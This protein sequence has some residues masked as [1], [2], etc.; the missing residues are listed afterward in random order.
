[1]KYGESAFDILYLVFA[2]FTGIVILLRHR[3]KADVLM[4]T[5][6]LVLGAGDAF[7]LVPRVVNYFSGSNLTWY[8]GLGKLV[9]SITMTVFYILVFYLYKT[10]YKKNDG[11]VKGV[12][13]TILILALA[14][15]VLC[16]M[17]GNNWFSG[18]GTVLW[19][20]LRNLPFIAIGALIVYLYYKVKKEDRY[21]ER[22]WI[23]TTL[24]FL[25]YIP[26]ALF[27]SL[28]PILGMLMLPKTICYILMLISFLRKTI[29]KDSDKDAWQR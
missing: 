7:H 16:L 8:F 10:V 23:Y 13:V 5:A 17:P 12:E 1:M 14:R 6:A 29:E 25:F 26:V 28:L 3:N 11:G 2:I 15:V 9:T 24:S 22:F 18:E 4:G 19:A 27:A 21:L 20:V